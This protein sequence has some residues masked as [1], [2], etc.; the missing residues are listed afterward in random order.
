MA[1][2]DILVD[3]FDGLDRCNGLEI[4]MATILPDEIGAVCDNPAIV[5]LPS[6]NLM[7]L[8]SVLVPG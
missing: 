5:N 8:S 3:V 2:V 6:M 7:C 4:D 1:L